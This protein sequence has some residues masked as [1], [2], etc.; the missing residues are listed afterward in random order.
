MVKSCKVRNFAPQELAAISRLFSSS[1]IRELARKGRS[2]SFIEL[3]EESQLL[4]KL[5]STASVFTV[6]DSAFTALKKEGYRDE[7]VYKT[8]LILRILLGRHSLRTASVLNEFRVE[9]CKADLVILNGT[10]TAYEVKSE[11]DSLARLE[12]QIETYSQCFAQVYVIAAENHLDAVKALIPNDVGILKL[13]NRLEISLVQK[14]L[15]RPER[16][17]SAVIFD[18]VRT[19]EARLILEAHGISIPKVPNTQLHSVLRELFT[20]LTN[21]D[22]HRGM[23]RVLKRTRN[24]WQFS[25]LLDQLP[26]SLYSAVFSTPLRR[27]DQ[28][29]LARAVRTSLNE[30]IKW[31]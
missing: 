6:F 17:S 25:D 8:A 18:S 14:A 3:A 19:V 9:D 12:R 20:K 29:R 30:A 26:L 15:D 23:V 24:L 13:S 1:V 21:L 16:T 2:R 4:G 10:A 27:V 5:S 11:R 28:A 22:A 31:A 7:Y